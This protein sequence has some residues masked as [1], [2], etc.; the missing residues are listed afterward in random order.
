MPQNTA[1]T[2]TAHIS[3]QTIQAVTLMRGKKL[4]HIAASSCRRSDVLASD[5]ALPLCRPPR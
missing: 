2:S 5:D 1:A 3:T 4:D